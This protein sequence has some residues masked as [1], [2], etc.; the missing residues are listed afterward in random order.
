MPLCKTSP[1]G[2]ITRVF[3]G[4]SSISVILSSAAGRQIVSQRLFPDN[5]R[6]GPRAFYLKCARAAHLAAAAR[7]T[8]SAGRWEYYVRGR[9]PN[10]PR[11]LWRRVTPI[12][13]RRR[14]RG[15]RL[16]ARDTPPGRRHAVLA[17]YRCRQHAT[18]SSWSMSPQ[19]LS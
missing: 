9:Y 4:R 3:I 5:E 6:H 7:V 10:R 15:T 16:F 12:A 19:L 17:H 2:A 13:K 18:A 14:T 8:G 1:R 11:R